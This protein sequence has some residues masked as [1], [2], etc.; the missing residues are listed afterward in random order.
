MVEP[1]V[2]K[3]SGDIQYLHASQPVHLRDKNPDQ[4]DGYYKKATE[5]NIY[6]AFVQKAVDSQGEVNES[7]QQYLDNTYIRVIK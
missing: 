4:S 3:T 6:S 2:N 5:N 1:E 7:P